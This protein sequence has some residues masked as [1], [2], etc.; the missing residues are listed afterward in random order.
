MQNRSF[1]VQITVHCTVRREFKHDIETLLS[2]Y[3]VCEH[4]TQ[5]HTRSDTTSD[6]LGVNLKGSL[7]LNCSS[8][9]YTSK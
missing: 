6:I 9:E 3:A 5:I 2:R 4:K 1:I 8:I 7:S